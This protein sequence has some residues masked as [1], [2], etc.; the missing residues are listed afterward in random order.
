VSV[1]RQAAELVSIVRE[2]LVL[3]AEAGI[4]YEAGA[5]EALVVLD[6]CLSRAH[7]DPASAELLLR[8]ATDLLLETPFDPVSETG[9][10]VDGFR[11]A[12]RERLE[13]RLSAPGVARNAAR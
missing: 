8:T 11:R 12:F 4:A 6:E 3:A 10:P 5:N 7:V 2:R 13:Q 9:A 1:T